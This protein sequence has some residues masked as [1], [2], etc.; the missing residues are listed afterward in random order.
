MKNQA[1]FSS[2]DKSKTL[3]D[4]CCNFC[5]VLQ[6]LNIS[7]NGSESVFSDFYFVMEYFANSEDP[8]LTDPVGL[9]CLLRK[10]CPN[11]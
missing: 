10:F 11:V 4:V 7:V 8:D 6:G 1:L 5:F 9:L 2:K 3:K